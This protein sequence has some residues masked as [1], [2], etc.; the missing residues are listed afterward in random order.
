MPLDGEASAEHPEP[1][2]TA[3]AAVV[4]ATVETQSE[5]KDTEDQGEAEAD[6]VIENGMETNEEGDKDDDYMIGRTAGEPAGAEVCSK[7]ITV[8]SSAQNPQETQESV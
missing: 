5:T 8:E 6:G 1:L 7:E 3:E 4:S 2:G